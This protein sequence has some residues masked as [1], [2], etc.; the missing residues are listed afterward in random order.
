VKIVTNDK[1]LPDD[2]L[3]VMQAQSEYQRVREF[4]LLPFAPMECLKH[5]EATDVNNS[6]QSEI[7]AGLCCCRELSVSLC[8]SSGLTQSN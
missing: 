5:L 7:R 2:G 1:N 6:I 3:P 8:C 4:L